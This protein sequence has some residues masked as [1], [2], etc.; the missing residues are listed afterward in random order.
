[1]KGTVVHVNPAAASYTMAIAGGE[2]VSVHATKLPLAGEKLTVEAAHHAPW[3][4]GRCAVLLVGETAVGYAGE[5]H[6]KV[7]T[8]F[9]VPA[10]TCAAE[11]DLDA[12][13][14]QAP[15]ITVA[16]PFS[17]FRRSPTSRWPRRTS[18]SSST[19]P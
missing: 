11:I 9:G 19:R 14:Q 1:M 10:R 18:R 16:Q 7:C 8:S 4:P 13:I 3:H 6:P 2:L 12:L 5:L 15:D 17:S